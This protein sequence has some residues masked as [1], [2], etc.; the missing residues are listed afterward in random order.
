MDTMIHRVA[1]SESYRTSPTL[2]RTSWAFRDYI[3]AHRVLDIIDAERERQNAAQQ[4]S[5]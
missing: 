1:T 5:G 2:V 3:D 4:R